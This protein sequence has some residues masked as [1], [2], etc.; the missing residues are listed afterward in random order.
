MKSMAESNGTRLVTTI[1]S[2]HSVICTADP[3]TLGFPRLLETR[4]WPR[5]TG[6]LSV[7]WPKK[8]KKLPSLLASGFSRALMMGECGV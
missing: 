1:I 5:L 6:L 2:Q 3:V 4:K 7:S 8:K